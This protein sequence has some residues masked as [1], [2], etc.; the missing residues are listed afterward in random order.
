MGFRFFNIGSDFR[1]I[2]AGVM[3]TR[4]QL[5]AFAVELNE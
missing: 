4:Q 2:R 5:A 3:E 1:Y